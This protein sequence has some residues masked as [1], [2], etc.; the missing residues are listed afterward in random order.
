ML[1]GNV[2]SPPSSC[3]PA[4]PIL[5]FLFP[6]SLPPFFPPLSFPL[7]FLPSILPTPPFPTL[8]SLP[9]FL[10]TTNS[11]LL[12]YYGKILSGVI[13]LGNI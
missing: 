2:L 11:Y 9:T 6:P 1:V 8:S 7:P 3:Q 5:L 13:A 12:K 10:K 4:L